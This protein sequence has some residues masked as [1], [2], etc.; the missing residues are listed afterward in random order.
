MN[1]ELDAAREQ[2]IQGLSRISHF[3]G[4][5]K[6]MGAIYG[7]IYLSPS[8][9]TLDDLVKQVNITKGAVSTNVRS[10]ERLKIIH[11]QY[12]VGDRK[13]YYVAETDFWKMI[14]NILKEREKAEFDHALKS[15][16]RSLEMVKSLKSDSTEMELAALYGERMQSIQV[17]F[18]KLDGLVATI[19]ALD[20]L[21]EGAVKKLFG[22]EKTTKS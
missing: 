10:L 3:W 22:K 15:V 17:F 9:L 1:K 8:P 14:K 16:E 19:I 13:D 7:A 5:S 21:R 4:F 6:A 2:F 12:K 18:N 11:K 20:E